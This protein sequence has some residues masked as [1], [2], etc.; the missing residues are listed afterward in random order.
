MKLE[1]EVEQFLERISPYDYI[2]VECL[3]RAISIMEGKKNKPGL[4][5]LSEKRRK[6]YKADLRAKF[7]S[8]IGKINNAN[9]CK[10]DIRALMTRHLLKLVIESRKSEFDLLVT[11]RVRGRMPNISST[12]LCLG[13]RYCPPTGGQ[14]ISSGEWK[15]VGD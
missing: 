14:N 1:E 6:T 7:E 11:V 15:G 10:R 9:L 2:T 13:P 12:T 8:K 5:L 4:D 3:Y